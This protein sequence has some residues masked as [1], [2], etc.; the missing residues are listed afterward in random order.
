[1]ALT[2][3]VVSTLN[4]PK[5]GELVKLVFLAEL[6]PDGYLPMANRRTVGFAHGRSP[7]CGLKS[8]EFGSSGDRSGERKRGKERLF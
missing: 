5:M 6:S 2:L 1:M 8:E 3:C 7:Y 4:S